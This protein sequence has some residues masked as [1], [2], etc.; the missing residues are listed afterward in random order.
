M[1]YKKLEKILLDKMKAKFPKAHGHCLILE[2][3][4]GTGEKTK[5]RIHLMAFYHN[6]YTLPSD[7]SKYKHAESLFY[8]AKTLAECIST[9]DQHLLEYTKTEKLDLP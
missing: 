9:C 1:D 7:D 3:R 5:Y 4:M 6:D 2:L 8:H